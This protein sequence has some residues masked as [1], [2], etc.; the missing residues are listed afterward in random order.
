MFNECWSTRNTEIAPKSDDQWWP[1]VERLMKVPNWTPFYQDTLVELLG[2]IAVVGGFSAQLIQAAASSQPVA[3]LMDALDEF[4]DDAPEHPAAIPLAFAMV[5]NL[6][7]I[8]RY[9]RSVNDM[10]RACREEGDIDALFDALSVDSYI[11]TMPFFQAALRLGQLSG[12]S[13]AAE[14]IFRSIKGPH[15][16]RLVYPQLRWAEY[17]LRDQGAFEACTQDEIHELLVV[18]LKLYGDD[19]ELKDSKKSLFML[20]R[21]WR[22]QAGI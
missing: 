2:K 16:K 12:D 15:K 20:F 1:A 13:D 10:L 6:D 21:K 7:A 17:L 18:H 22:K 5:G 3:A 11:S 14:Q 9:S 8:A 4:P 19:V